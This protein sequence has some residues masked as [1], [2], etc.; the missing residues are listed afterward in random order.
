[1]RELSMRIK[2]MFEAKLNSSNGAILRLVWLLQKRYNERVW[3]FVFL[4]CG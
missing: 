3:V 1:M 4:A 2:E